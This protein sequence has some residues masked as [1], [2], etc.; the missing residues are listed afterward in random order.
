MGGKR[1]FL[2]IIFGLVLAV[3][4]LAKVQAAPPW[5]NL[6]SFKQIEAEPDKTYALSENNGPWMIMACSFSGDGAEKQAQELVYELRKRY[7]L[8]AYI[9]KAQFDFGD[10]KGLGV[11]RFGTPVKMRYRKG[12]EIKEVAVLVGDYPVRRPAVFR[13]Q[14]KQGNLSVLGGI[15]NH[16]GHGWQCEQGKR[17]N[18]SCFHNHKSAFAQRLFCTQRPG[19]SCHRDE[20][21]CHA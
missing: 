10:A 7:K 13:S 15:E 9:H 18:G 8:P 21:K 4:C 20:Q 5:T 16:T 19:S 12:S 2:L 3:C 11:D 1:T 17:A 14:I 6:V